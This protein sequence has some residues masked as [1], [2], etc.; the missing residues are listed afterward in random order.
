MDYKALIK[1]ILG[2][3]ESYLREYSK[4]E[5]LSDIEKG[6]LQ[7]LWMDVDS[8]NNRLEIERINGNKEAIKLKEEFDLEKRMHDMIILFKYWDI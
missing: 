6:I 5:K 3:S 2:N 1:H 4:K 8:I 7:G